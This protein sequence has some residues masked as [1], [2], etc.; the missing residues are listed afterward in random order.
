MPKWTNFPNGVTSLGIP[1]VPGLP[2]PFTG[3]YFWVNETTGYDGNPGTPSAPYKTLQAAHDATTDGNND[4]VLFSGTCHQTTSLNWSNSQTHLIGVC[5]DIKRGKRARISVTGTVAFDKLVNVT[6][7]GCQFQNFGTFY[8]FNDASANICWY[9]AGGRNAYDLVEFMG[10]G[11]GTASTGT[12]NHTAAR[13][14]TFNN[15]TG[16]TTWRNCVFGVDTITR[17]A[18]N[19]TL[20][21]AGGAPRLYFENC[22]FEAYLGASGGASSHVLVGAAGIDRYVKFVGCRFGASGQSGGTTMAQCFNVNGA[23]GGAILL[24]QCTA[25]NGITAW[26]TT[27]VTAVVQNMTVPT[28]GGGI[29]RE[30]P[31]T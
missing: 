30:V 23:P 22:D 10:F 28:A 24:D 20:E 11:D 29:A 15:S 31:G 3:N 25:F 17:N 21:L 16:E 2:Q 5:E 1:V 19:Y 7:Q 14:F 8:G 13:A 26:M 12:A 6:G 18:T 4:V 9:D 27:P